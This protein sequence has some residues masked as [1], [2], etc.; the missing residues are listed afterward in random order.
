MEFPQQPFIHR[1][2][3]ILLHDGLPAFRPDH[4]LHHAGADLGDVPRRHE[5]DRTDVVIQVA[6]DVAHRAFELVIR[7]RSYA[8][9]N[10]R[11]ADRLGVF[12]QVPV[13]E[14]RH[15]YVRQIF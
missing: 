8:A 6:V 10:V 7:F 14:G 2:W 13:R 5:K 1:R 12:D 3:H 4:S 9:H 15:R 11:R